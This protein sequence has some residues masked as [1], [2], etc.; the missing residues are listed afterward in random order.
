[1]KAINLADMLAPLPPVRFPTGAECAVRPFTAEAYELYRA[2]RGR[3]EKAVQG[4]G[5]NEDEM[6]EMLSRLLA[7]VVPD[8]TPDDLASLGERFDAKLVPV[9]LAAGRVEEVMAAMHDVNAVPEGNA[10]R[11]LRSR[12]GTSSAHKSRGTPKRLANRGGPS[13]VK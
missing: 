11:P 3:M 5:I 9:M 12:G 1:M 6:Q 10:P 4:E 13:I 7:L 8:A 2:L